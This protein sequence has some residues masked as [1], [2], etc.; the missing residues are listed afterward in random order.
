MEAIWNHTFANELRVDPKEHPVVLTEPPLNPKVNR[1]RM[2]QIMFDKFKVPGVYIGIQAVLAL[3]ASGRTTGV[4]LDCGDGVTHV[5]PIY[6]GYSLP[7]AIQRLDLAGRDLTDYMIRLLTERGYSF[8]TSAEREIVR[9]IK[10]QLCYVAE[11]PEEEE[12]RGRL[13]PSKLNRNYILPDG[14][15]ITITTA[16]FLSVEPLFAP[17][18]LGMDTVGIH[19]LLHSSI[20][21]C[22]VDIRR[23]MFSNIVLSG[24]TTS[25]PGF[26][27]RM[28]IELARLTVG[29]MKIKISTFDKPQ[30]AVW[31]G[32]SVM[33]S[34]LTFEDMWITRAEYEQSG[35]K[36]VH[37]K[38]F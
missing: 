9:D 17:S 27:R 10:E 12:L 1:E 30:T 32:A 35:A 38:C 29:S 4:V 31:N 11:D 37:R 14:Q 20:M 6:E 36:I 19:E 21:K 26:A 8:T 33:A 13:D 34:L 5:V 15:V 24:G 18:L 28:E 2:V 16:R 22:D 3:Y 23:D 25:L 7:H